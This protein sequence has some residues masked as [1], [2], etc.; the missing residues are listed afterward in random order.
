MKNTLNTGF[1][2]RKS[3]GADAEGLQV[4]DYLASFYAAFSKEEWLARIHSGRVL[5]DGTPAEERQKLSPGQVLTW[6]RP[7]WNEPEVPKPFA[8][9]YK[10]EHLLAV[11]KPSGLPTLP[12][13]GLFME[14][15]L[16]SFVRRHFPGANP[17]HRLGRGTSGIVLFGLARDA[18][19]NILQAWRAGEILKVYRALAA[20]CPEEDEFTIDAAIGPVPHL[21]LKTVHGAC[22]NGKPAHSH[23][24]VL[25]RRGSCSL[26][27]VRITTGRPHQIRI[28][29]AAAGYPLVGDP[30]Y[31]AGGVPAENSR[32]LPSDLGYALHNGLLGFLHPVSGKWTEVPCCPP[33]LLRTRGET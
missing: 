7:P 1:E 18:A 12:A 13:G 15:T 24:K 32:A 4:I 26:V 25:E 10:D 19:G 22:S 28:H 6:I 11:A 20:G 16:L 17:L 29:L 3:L 33:P 21:I 5:L 31:R 9:L 27:Q 30:L 2:Y 8:I 14:N 23:V